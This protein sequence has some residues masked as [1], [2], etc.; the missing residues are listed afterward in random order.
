V[1]RLS[2]KKLAINMQVR[3]GTVLIRLEALDM[4]RI[5]NRET[6]DSHI[7]TATE[8]AASQTS[9]KRWHTHLTASQSTAIAFVRH[10]I[11][12]E[13]SKEAGRCCWV[14]RTWDMMDDWTLNNNTALTTLEM[15]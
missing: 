3:L 7:H 5:G 11:Q 8:F 14:I 10:E 4:E 12:N 2:Q 9:A 13:R 15:P 6:E 1:N